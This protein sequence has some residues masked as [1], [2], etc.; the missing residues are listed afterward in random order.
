MLPDPMLPIVP[1]PDAQPIYLESIVNRLRELFD[2]MLDHHSK[3]LFLRFDLRFPWGGQFPSDN[4]HLMAFTENYT[5]VLR[6][7]GLDPRYLWVREQ[8]E[9]STPPHYHF[10][11][12]LNGHRTQSIRGHLAL[13]ADTWA[14]TLGLPS[15]YHGQYGDLD[16]E[17]PYT[18]GLS[19]DGLVHFC[20]RGG[21][22][23]P[24]ENGVMIRKDQP[25]WEAKRA[26]CVDWGMYLA[27]KA[28]KSFTPFGVRSFGSSRL[29]K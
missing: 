24:H 21:R 19:S 26:Y 22:P 12:L 13:A 17:D 23:F 27:K 29:P 16:V 10:V 25:D 5:Y 15:P 9:F 18:G 4:T 6:C 20:L 28:S 1:D 3:V 14:S 7:R 2:W 11:V 8:T